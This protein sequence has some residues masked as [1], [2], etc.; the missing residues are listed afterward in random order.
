[1]KPWIAL[2]LLPLAAACL[3]APCPDWPVPRAN[4]EIAAL[5]AQIAHWD[6]A[7]HRQGLSLVA[8]ELYDQARARLAH[9]RQCFP[10]S[11]GAAAAPLA[12]S[13]GQQAHPIAHTGLEKLADDAA[14]QG[15]I[16][17]RDRLWIQPKVDGV[18]V[19][20]VYRD[21]RL[22]QAISRG[23]GRRGQDWTG[24]ALRLPAVPQQLPDSL[25][26]ILQGE[27]YWRLDAHVQAEAGALGARAKVAG[28]L[29]RKT[30]SEQQAAGIGLFVWDWPDGPRDMRE[31]LERL[32]GLG[33]ADSQRFSQRIDG[34]L[35]ARHWR[36]HWY[37]SALPFASDGVVLRQDRRPPGRRWRAEPPAWAAAWKYP[38]RQA[39]AEV[40]AV[41]FRIGRR[42]RITPVLRLLPVRLDDRRIESISLGSL[43]R[44]QALD[45]RP[46]D[47]VS[48]RLAGATVAQL[49]EV[50]WRTR[51]RTELAVPDADAY[52]ALSCW[53]DTPACAEQ[54]RARLSW[55]GGKQGLALPGVGP[56]TWEKLLRAR[57]FDGLLGWL[58]LSEEQ[59]AQVPG[60]S[61]AAAAQ[62][63]ASL[64]QAR[65]RPSSDWLRGLGLPAIAPGALD[66]DWDALAARDAA[67]WQAEP[68]IGP[69][70]AAQLQA[71]FHHPEV[72]ALH[73]QLQAQGIAGF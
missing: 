47:Q 49:D 40:R 53:R 11:A 2:C 67:R 58:E 13:A 5:G 66:A 46:G 14:V 23:D 38:P 44:W 39:L 17:S 50:I 36:E 12:S 7:Y 71:F 61:Q 3:A 22:V 55:L 69:I 34:Y 65:Q 20:L 43:Q 26:L 8:D 45:L 33:F 57:S 62:L 32:A 56:G 19:T 28:L 42:G 73:A 54:F 72:L 59:L 31:R 16:A 48:I 35:A 21:G 37:R 15:W 4:T 60:L 68:G 6:D 1:M 52:H 9:W 30:L 51:E 25:A 18:A 70:R 63:A 27:L 29:A 41:D 64:A 24:A 10:A